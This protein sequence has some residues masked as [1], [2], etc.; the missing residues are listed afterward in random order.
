V[1]GLGV[2]KKV[3]KGPLKQGFGLTHGPIVTDGGFGV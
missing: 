3:V 1:K 2:E